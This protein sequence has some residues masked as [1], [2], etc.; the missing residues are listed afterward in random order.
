MIRVTNFHQSHMTGVFTFSWE[1]EEGN[2]FTRTFPGKWVSED[3]EDPGH[4][5]PDFDRMTGADRA[6]FRKLDDIYSDDCAAYWERMAE[7]G[8]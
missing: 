6:L 2:E 1:D 5:E 7:R 8:Y 3:E 4:M